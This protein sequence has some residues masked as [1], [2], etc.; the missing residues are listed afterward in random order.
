VEAGGLSNWTAVLDA[1]Q[2]LEQLTAGIV[3]SAEYAATHGTQADAA[4]VTGLYQDVLGRA[5]DE[6]GFATWT[7][8]LAGGTS[9]ATVAAGFLFSAEAIEQLYQPATDGVLIA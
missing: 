5:A 6:A 8:A 1:R 3:G 7:S 9:R 2:D 4:F